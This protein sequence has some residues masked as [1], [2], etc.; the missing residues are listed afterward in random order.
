EMCVDVDVSPRVHFVENVEPGTA[1][2]DDVETLRETAASPVAVEPPSPNW[3]PTA[4][5]PPDIPVPAP[6]AHGP[7]PAPAAAAPASAPPAK[8][9]FKEWQARRKLE[10]ATVEEQEERDREMQRGQEMKREKEQREREKDGVDKENDAVPSKGEDGLT[11]ILDGIRRSAVGDKPPSVEAVQQDVEMPDAGP[12]EIAPAP[13]DGLQPKEKGPLPSMTAFT[14]SPHLT[15]GIKREVSP[16]AATVPLPCVPRSGSQPTPARMSP[17][18]ASTSP[19]ATP[20]GPPILS[21]TCTSSGRCH[22]T[23]RSR[24]ERHRIPTRWHSAGALA[25]LPAAPSASMA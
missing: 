11:R 18:T 5:L 17:F 23:H 21:R 24:C 25:A 4:S 22:P 19:F 16:L 20:N 9:S 14:P 7:S 8:V 6:L 2:V 15:N 12:V 3:D 1:L 10:R 13:L